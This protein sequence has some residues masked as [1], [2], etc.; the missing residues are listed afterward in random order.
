MVGGIDAGIYSHSCG[1]GAVPVMNLG[2]SCN[3]NPECLDVLENIN[4]SWVPG[5]PED[6]PQYTRSAEYLDALKTS[7]T[8]SSEYLHTLKNI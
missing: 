2:E 4:V 6:H 5:H 3:S 7:S 1:A 8:R